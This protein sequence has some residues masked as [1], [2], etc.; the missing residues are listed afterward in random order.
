MRVCNEA[1]R[2]KTPHL[3]SI[4][5]QRYG[6]SKRGEMAITHKPNFDFFVLIQQD[7]WVYQNDFYFVDIV[8][9]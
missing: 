3:T 9:T 4:A 2:Q 8:L 1:L 7:Y 5:L 6:V